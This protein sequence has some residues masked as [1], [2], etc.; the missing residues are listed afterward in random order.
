MGQ[1]TEDGGAVRWIEVVNLRAKG[2]SQD[3]DLGVGDATHLGFDLGDRASRQPPAEHAA[4]GRKL[5]L[6]DTCGGPQ[7]VHLRANCIA[8]F[9]APVSELDG[10]RNPPQKCSDIGAFF[11]SLTFP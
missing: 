7:T 5:V 3:K 6:S 1:V 9:H 2:A 4:T 11:Y 8:S 10:I